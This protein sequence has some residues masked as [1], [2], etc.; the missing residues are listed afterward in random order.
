MKL[1]AV[2]ACPW[3]A[4]STRGTIHY[5]VTPFVLRESDRCWETSS[6][7]LSIDMETISPQLWE[8][9][10]VLGYLR[11]LGRKFRALC[12]NEADIPLSCVEAELIV[13]FERVTE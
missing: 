8:E 4:T 11:H 5:C 2:R 10:C 12:L 6:I 1:R 3:N 13:C 9:T 7:P